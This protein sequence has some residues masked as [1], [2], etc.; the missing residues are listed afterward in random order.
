VRRRDCLE[1]LASYVPKDTIVAASLSSNSSMWSSLRPD[2]ANF[3]GLNMGLSVPFALGLTLAFPK[4]KV[5]ALESDGSLMVDGSSLITLADVNPSNLVVLVF[6]NASYARMG[7]TFTSRAAD[8]E[9]I[10]EG[11]GV[12]NTATVRT[13]EEFALGVKRAFEG[14]GLAFLV[15]KVEPDKERTVGNPRFYGRPMRERF[16]D[17]TMRRPDYWGKKSAT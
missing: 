11:A 9:K 12:R 13:Q 7:P 5:L 10:A 17:V 16:V 14:E 3:F 15:V 4:T 8:I 1:W 2:G 6:D